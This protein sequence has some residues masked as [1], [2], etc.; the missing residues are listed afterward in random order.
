MSKVH[1]DNE[2]YREILA[3]LL[4]TPMI[5]YAVQA[6]VDS[7]NTDLLVDYHRTNRPNARSPFVEHLM[8][9]GRADLLVPTLAENLHSSRNIP[10]AATVSTDPEVRERAEQR[11]Q[12]I[13]DLM[14]F[15]KRGVSIDAALPSLHP[16]LANREHGLN[17]A[18][19]IAQGGGV[20]VLLSA[21]QLSGK[22]ERK[23]L[24]AIHGLRHVP[25]VSDH[26][27]DKLTDCL[28]HPDP[29]VRISACNTLSDVISRATLPGDVL[30]ALAD[31]ARNDSDPS[32]A[33]KSKI[34]LRKAAGL[35]PNPEAVGAALPPSPVGPGGTIVSGSGRVPYFQGDE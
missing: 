17:I 12:S 24:N 1:V 18:R 26:V 33:A 11:D 23:T 22:I 13:R 4:M 5:G 15:S 19:I 6:A 31:R 25:Q 28:Q 34:I 20:D 30:D 29:Q 14:R 27:F 7:D 9:A 32:V 21:I 8:K 3:T 35:V 2:Q 16:L 10:G